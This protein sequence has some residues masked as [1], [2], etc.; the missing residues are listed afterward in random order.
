VSTSGRVVHYSLSFSTNDDPGW[1]LAR[2]QRSVS[3]L[4]PH[5]RG[6]DVAVFAYERQPQ[7]LRRSCRLHDAQLQ[8]QGSYAQCLA[9]LCSGGWPVLAHHPGLPEFLNFRSLAGTFVG[10]ALYCD[11]DIVFGADVERLFDAYAQDDLYAREEVHTSQ[12]SHGPG[13]EFLDEPALRA[14]AQFLGVRF[15]PHRNR[16]APPSELGV[17]QHARRMGRQLCLSPGAVDVPLSRSRCRQRLRHSQRRRCGA[18][19]GLPRAARQGTPLP[20][21]QSR[22]RRGDRDL[23]RPGGALGG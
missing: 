23:A 11:C 5:N 21:R 13:P 18:P 19:V 7:Q 10:Q 12:N 3:S 17:T 15:I 4:R 8:V 16:F 2:L 14:V 1:L 6:I 20:R 9:Y 22:D